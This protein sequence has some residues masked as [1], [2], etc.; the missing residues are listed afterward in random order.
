[1][2]RVTA[3]RLTGINVALAFVGVLLT[4]WLVIAE[5]F[6]ETTCPDL[7]G[8]PACFLVLAAY[9]ATAVGAWRPD[10]GTARA[11]L[12]VGAGTVTA[13]GIYFTL[14][15]VGGA[16]PI[17]PTSS[18]LSAELAASIDGHD[19][20][21]ALKA[22]ATQLRGF[23]HRHPGLYDSLLPAPT[24]DE[25]P[26]VAAAL[27]EP[28]QIVGSVLA[29]MGVDPTAVIPLVRTLR[30]TVHGFVDIEL[31]GGF[32]LPDDLDVSF[33]TAVGVVV[34]AIVAESSSRAGS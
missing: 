17:C 8:V 27:G 14:S 30:A 12:L 13:I 23:A 4:S 21:E 3:E 1:M 29:G 15:E 26:E 31:R 9:L 5:L 2:H 16:A 7:F 25:D 20:T 10:S 18:L 32:G 19:P 28:V 33:A 22:A 11:I 6:R 34:D 24:P